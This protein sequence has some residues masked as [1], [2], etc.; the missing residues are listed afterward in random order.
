MNRSGIIFVNDPIVALDLA[1]IISECLAPIQLHVPHTVA[2]VAS[3]MKNAVC[4]VTDRLG[5]QELAPLQYASVIP[6]IYLG[7]EDDVKLSE[8]FARIELPFTN[9]A[10]KDAISALGL[11]V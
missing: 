9:G 2:E 4:L 11:T 10:V 1:E 5:A 3:V 6:H 8:R 7:V